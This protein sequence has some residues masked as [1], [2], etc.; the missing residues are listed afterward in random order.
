MPYKTFPQGDG[1]VNFKIDAQGKK[2]GKALSNKPM[3]KE[4]AAKQ[5]KALYASEKKTAKKEITITDSEGNQETT[6]KD[7]YE[8]EEK[9]EPDPVKVEVVESGAAVSFAELMAQAEAEELHELMCNLNHSFKTLATNIMASEMIEDRAQALTNLA[10]EYQEMMST[11]VKS[12]EEAPDMED[13]AIKVGKQIAG[14]N[15]VKKEDS[16]KEDESP[17]TIWKENGNYY[18]LLAYSN[19]RRDDDNPPEIIASESHKEFDQALHNKEWPMPE[20]WLW[21]IPYRVGQVIHHTYSEDTGFPVALAMF[22]KDK[23]DIAEKIMQSPDWNGVSHGMPDKWIQRSKED[24]SVIVRHRTKEVSIL[25]R[26]AA[27]NKAAFSI[28]TKESNMATDEKG[29]PVHKRPEFV[30][31]LGEERTKQVEEVLDKTSKEL[32]EAGVETKETKE[33]TMSDVVKA[34]EF[35]TTEIVAIKQEMATKEVVKEE[36][37]FDLVT[38]LKSLSVVGQETTKVDGRTKEAKDG[39]EETKG[40]SPSQEI[41][42]LP[43]SL[44]DKIFQANQAWYNGGVK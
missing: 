26:W 37:P 19:N 25:P 16:K 15:Q 21:H 42:G 39:P 9:Y 18:C 23:S 17:L 27:A 22:D 41:A 4:E 7:Y 6:T 24:S 34:L 13:K 2:I 35:L 32:N 43:V 14:D 30:K 28:I 5:L 29:L 36:E 31:L 8:Y 3:S 12:P 20:L 1:F 10:V 40:V 11:Y 33:P 44:V 38:R